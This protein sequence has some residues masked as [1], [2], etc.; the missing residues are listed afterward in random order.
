MPH[1]LLI[2][3]LQVKA[4]TAASSHVMQYGDLRLNF[5]KLEVYMGAATK[6]GGTLKELSGG[7]AVSQRDADLLHFW[8]K[9]GSLHFSLIHDLTIQIR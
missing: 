5:L 3:E 6:L 2:L 4:R 1:A 7:G 9:V 8:H